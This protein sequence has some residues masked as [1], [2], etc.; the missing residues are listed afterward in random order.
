M[1]TKLFLGIILLFLVSCVKKSDTIEVIPN[2][3]A[4]YAWKTDTEAKPVKTEITNEFSRKIT[5]QLGEKAGTI[6][7]YTLYIGENGKVDKIRVESITDKNGKEMLPKNS[8]TFMGEIV[9]EI[10]D[11]KFEPAIKNGKPVKSKLLFELIRIRGNDSLKLHFKN[12][13][14]KG[15]TETDEDVFFVAVEEM[16]EPIGGVKSVQ[17]NVTYPDLARRAGIQGRVFVKTFIDEKGNVVKTEII[18]GIGGGCDEAAQIAVEKAKFIPGKQRGVPVKTQVVMPILFRLSANVDFI[19][20]KTEDGKLPDKVE[21]EGTVINA[22]NEA[23]IA[24]ANIMLVGTR[25]GS[26]SDFEGNFQINKVPPGKYKLNFNHSKYGGKKS[27]EFEFKKGKKY[28]FKIK[29]TL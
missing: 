13:T 15:T 23:P 21:I 7:V 29:V 18:K 1:K 10:N 11:W 25:F 19:L 6:G 12:P 3:D 24:A 14:Q 27:N 5:K 16:P 17:K 20:E 4:V 26:A 8:Q 2:Y 28:I 9:K 22:Q